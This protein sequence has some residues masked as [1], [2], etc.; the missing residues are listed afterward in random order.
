M[1]EPVYTYILFLFIYFFTGTTRLVPYYLVKTYIL[2]LIW[3]SENSIEPFEL[4]SN[5]YYK[6]HLSRQQN[7]WSLITWHWYRLSVLLQLHLH[8]R[9]TPGF[10]GLGKD[11]CKMRRESFMFRYLVIL[12]LEFYSTMENWSW[13]RP[14]DSMCWSM[15]E[16][17][18]FN[19]SWCPGSWHCQGAILI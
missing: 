16:L 6:E 5:L 8:S 3:R 19:A 14:Q 12:I 18:Q 1:H 2:W 15:R 11:S 13:N 7:C 4:P 9:L 10:N 17:R